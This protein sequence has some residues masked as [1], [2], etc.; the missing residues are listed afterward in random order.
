[1]GWFSSG[2]Y[3]RLS[4]PP[5]APLAHLLLVVL[6]LAAG[7]FAHEQRVRLR[8][9]NLPLLRRA[10]RGAFL[11]KHERTKRATKRNELSELVY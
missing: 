5:P 4:Q 1:M 9:V 11:I 2:S 3:A 8:M 6:L 10:K 7:H